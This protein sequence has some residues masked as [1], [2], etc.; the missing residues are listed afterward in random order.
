MDRQGR[1]FLDTLP[2]IV[3]VLPKF[4]LQVFIKGYPS[5]DS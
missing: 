4:D 1:N 2:D 3:V 5:D